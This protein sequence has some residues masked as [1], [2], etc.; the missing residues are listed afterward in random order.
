MEAE[1]AAV[2]RHSTG[3]EP[4]EMRREVDLRYIGQGYELTVPFES[5]SKAR[6]AFEELYARRYGMAS[7]E[8]AVEATTWRLTAVGR[9][10]TVELPHFQSGVLPEPHRRRAWF[11]ESEGWTEAAVYRRDALPAGARLR[12]PAIVEERESTTVL[13]PDMEAEVDAYG[14]LLVSA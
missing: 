5:A 7:P 12:G 10:A 1:A 13:P 11:P 3:D 6:A 2:V 8:E 4:A 9:L 14:N